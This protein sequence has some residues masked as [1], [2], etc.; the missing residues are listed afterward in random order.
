[1]KH[2]D[3]CTLFSNPDDRDILTRKLFD[4]NMRL[5]EDNPLYCKVVRDCAEYIRLCA[6]TEKDGY[7]KPHGYSGAN[8]GIPFNII[9]LA[10]GTVMLNP[11]IIWAEGE[12]VIETNCGSLMLDKPITV[13]RHNRIAFIYYDLN[14][15]RHD[16]EG[17]WP[18]VQHEVDHNLGILITD[19]TRR[20][21]L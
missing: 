20:V 4:V 15:R 9:A 11:K 6:T 3:Y 13:K 2:E 8:A 18:T 17:Y 7:K 10:D 12:R 5:F 1:M 14:G 16:E 21:H 19:P